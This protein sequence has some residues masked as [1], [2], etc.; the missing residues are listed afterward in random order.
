MSQ[1]ALMHSLDETSTL[2]RELYGLQDKRVL[3]TGASKGIGEAVAKACAGAGAQLL[4]AGRDLPRLQALLDA[5]P[6]DGHR[7]FTGDLC[8]ANIVQ[9]LATESGP[10]D[11]VVHSAGI[12]GLSPM[13]LISESTFNEVTTINYIAPTMLTR[14]LLARQ[15]LRPGG[16]IVFLSSIAA[17]TGTVGV[18]A[19]SGSKA[20]L[21]GVLR[22]LALELARRKIRANALCP[23]LVNTTLVNEHK[24]WLAE[25]AK[26][27]PLG[28]GQ[29]EDI[30]LACL[31]FLS[32][33]SSKVTGQ[34]FNMD[35]GVELV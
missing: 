31:Y 19:Y 24:D 29:P 14:H 9:R 25:T 8:D 32:D 1:E 34:A 30:A 15:A 18:G 23:A 28:I 6:G 11:G 21:I 20:A 13:K 3:I 33:A 12:R 10:L 26:R 2:L 27:Y 35:G 7:L 5:L 22:P 16:S 17:L 4:V